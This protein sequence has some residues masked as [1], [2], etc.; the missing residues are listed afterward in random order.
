MTETGVRVT[1]KIVGET[2]TGFP[3][4]LVSPRPP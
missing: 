4:R 3:D 1:D 2:H